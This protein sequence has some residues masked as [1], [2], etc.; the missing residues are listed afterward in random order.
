MQASASVAL[1]AKEPRRR[2][3]QSRSGIPFHHLDSRGCKGCRRV[4]ARPELSPPHARSTEQGH[5]G[6]AVPPLP[7]TAPTTQPHNFIFRREPFPP[8]LTLTLRD[9][10][11]GLVESSTKLLNHQPRWAICAGL[12]PPQCR[13]DSP[14]AGSCASAAPPGD[15]RRWKQTAAQTTASHRHPRP[16]APPHPRFTGCHRT[17]VARS[18]IPLLRTRERAQPPGWMGG[19]GRR[20]SEPPAAWRIPHL[21][22]EDGATA[23]GGRVYGELQHPRRRH[24]VPHLSREAPQA[25]AVMLRYSKGRRWGWSFY[26]S[27]AKQRASGGHDR[28][29]GMSGQRQPPAGG[30]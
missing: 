7:Q 17:C 29:A 2:P 18:A 16:H 3:P 12:A 15:I 28:Q 24:S 4:R 20:G 10:R 13:C 23:A 25:R 8:T 6:P 1:G 22:H 19:R 21:V 27:A 26:G 9:N 5:R 11:T 30:M 14:R